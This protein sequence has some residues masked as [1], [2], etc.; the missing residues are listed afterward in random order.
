VAERSRWLSDVVNRDVQNPEPYD[1]L[2]YT[3][4]AENVVRALLDQPLQAMPPATPFSGVGVYAVWY[5]GELEWYQNVC[6]EKRPIYVGSAVPTGGRKG[7]TGQPRR[8]RLYNRLRQ[9]SRSIEQAENL[10]LNDFS[11]RYLVVVPVWIGLAERF[12]IEHF[13]PV[14]NTVVDGF[15][16][17]DPGRGRRDMKRPRWDILHPGR[18]W[19]EKLRAEETPEEIARELM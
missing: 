15:G 1:P 8:K 10:R 18:Y 7:G 5:E 3:H 6:G 19:A 16:N 13:G 17:H 14:W 11:C 2:D 9:H 4:L 12:L